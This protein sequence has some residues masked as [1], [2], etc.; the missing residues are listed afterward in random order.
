MNDPNGLI[1]RGD[2]HHLFFQHNPHGTTMGRIH[3]GHATSTDLLTW[4]EHP[5]A[6]HP[7]DAGDYDR[8]GC[9]SGCAVALPDG[10]VAVLY[11]GNRDGRQLPCL[12]ISSDPGLHEWVKHPV[13]PVIARWPSITAITDHRDHAVAPVGDHYRQVVAVGTDH[14]GQLVSY[15]SD[16]QD[17]SAWTF[18]TTVLTAESADLPG[19]VWECPDL[20]VVDGVVTVILSWFNGDGGGSDDYVSDVVWLTGDLV[21]GRFVPQRYGR[22]DVG[23]R[24]YAPQSYTVGDGRRILF[25]WLRTQDDPASARSP[26][27]GAM[28]LPREVFVAD[29]R[30]RQRPAA[31]VAR[32]GRSE[33]GVLDR[34]HPSLVLA[35]DSGALE[36]LVDSPGPQGLAGVVLEL[37]S[38]E[39]S[40]MA[41][42]LGALSA[43][44]M[45]VRCGG[46]W[47]SDPSHSTRAQVLVDAGLVEV[48]LDDGR[49]AALSDL[50]LSRVRE[51]SM[52]MAGAG[53]ADRAVTVQIRS[54]WRLADADVSHRPIPAAASPLP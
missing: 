47:L 51:V 38:A 14:G 10:S 11:S 23:D 45:W 40:R 6:L 1:Q 21:G 12:A 53:P 30:L 43:P 22:L 27:V 20:F 15:R 54:L 5:L 39:G 24:F 17:L 49:A 28:S 7:G 13:N 44:S 48:F 42:D 9:W 33:R 29:G 46:R 36:L 3:W 8:D 19:R 37:R 52:R 50:R 2:V 4:T 25:G 31:E 34:R 41:L 35:E 26:S 32:L 16:G 18:E